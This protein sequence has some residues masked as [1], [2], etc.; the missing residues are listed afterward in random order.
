MK[1]VQRYIILI[2]L[3]LF[4][5]VPS[6]FSDE[7]VTIGHASAGK[8]IFNRVCLYCHTHDERSKIGPSLMGIGERRS[9][10]WLHGWLKNPS[11]M[12]KND[13]DAKVV[14]GK[15]KF[16]MVMP[17]LPDMQD[18]QKRSD[19]IAYLLESF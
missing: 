7:H 14:R 6:A 3:L 15:S 13:V 16:N 8:E 1:S 10:A 12:I 11:K 17:A 5:F 19:V 2:G 18:V 4:S 9:E